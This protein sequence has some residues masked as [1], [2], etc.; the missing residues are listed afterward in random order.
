MNIYN[1]IEYTDGVFVLFLHENTNFII[2]DID[3]D[4]NILNDD[5]KLLLKDVDFK[6]YFLYKSRGGFKIIVILNP[7]TFEKKYEIMNYITQ[8]LRGDIVMIRKFEVT[9]AS[10]LRLSPKFYK[11]EEEHFKFLNEEEKEKIF[12]VKKQMKDMKISRIQKKETIDIENFFNYIETNNSWA[13][14]FLKIM[15]NNKNYSIFKK[16]KEE[17]KYSLNLEEQKIINFIE[18]F[19][20]LNENAILI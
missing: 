5:Y 13:S 7:T 14:P 4:K 12:L 10:F 15:Y 3:T 17:E 9:R 20:T 6:K 2:I 1:I 19:T 8:K 11:F 18:N 16:I